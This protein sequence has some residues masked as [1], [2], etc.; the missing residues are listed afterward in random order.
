M[1][2]RIIYN[3]YFIGFM[4]FGSALCAQTVTGIVTDNNGPMPGAN[5]IVK[6]T[7]LGTATDFDGNYTIENVAS[8]AVLVFSM[9]G[10]ATQEVSVNGQSQINIKLTEDLQSLDEVVLVGYS[11]R[12]KS[13]LTGAVSVVDMGDLE[14]TRVVNVTQA[15]QGQI[16]GV[17]V[18]SSTGAPGDP[19]EVRIRGL[20]TIGDNN[21]LYV[22]D[23]IPTRD[24]GFLNQADIKSMT[25]LKDASAAAIYGSRASGGVVLITTKSGNE[26]KITFD[27]NYFTGLHYASNLPNMLNAEQYM[28][29]VEKAWNNSDRTGV[30]PY[31]ADKGRADF[32]NTDWLD[33]LFETGRS[34]NLQFTA[35]GGSDKIQFLMS[36]GYYGQDGMVIFDNDKYK[37]LSYRTNLNVDLTDRLKIG[38]NLQLTYATQDKLSSK[39]DAP[40]IIRHA[41]LRPPVIGVYKNVNDPTYSQRDP[42]TDLPFYLHN[43]RDNG[44]WESDKYEWSQNPIALAYFTDDVRKDFRTFGNIYAEYSFLK[45]KELTF[46]TNVGVDLSFIHNKAFR[47]NFGDDDGGGN[48][49]DQGLGRQNRPNNLSEERGEAR[50]ITFNNTLNYAKAFNDKHDISALIGMEYIDNY[51]S[52]I[53]ASRARFD[54]TD[55]TFRYIDYGATEADLWNGG[56]A[57][58]WALFSYFGSASY[59]LD[60]KYMVTAN[61]RA[62][63]SSR[64]SEKNRWGYFP[65]ISA[66]WKISDEAFLKD[67]KWLSNL[68]LRAGWGKLGNQEIDNYAFLTLINQTDGK[69]VVNR[70]GNEDLKW[71]SSEST[72]IGVDVGFLKN[73]LIFSAEYYVK[74]T[75]DILL[76]IG[77]PSI[78]G[79]VSPTIVNAGE[80]SNK[81]FEFSLNYRESSKAFQYSINANLGTVVNNVEKLH[82]NVPNLVGEVTRTQVGQPLNAY[83]GYKMI[84]IYQNQAEIDS[85]LS[86]TLNPSVKPGDI[87]FEDL[88]D[89][90][91]VNSDDRKFLGSSIP[92]L[93]YGMS[94]SSSYKNFDF[95]FLFQGVEGVDRYNDSK[96]ILDYDTRPFN[97]TTNILGAW[98]GEGTSNTIPRVAFEDNGSSK[99]SSIFVEDA[100]YLRLK[101]IELGYT[102][103]SVKGVQDI[104]LYVSGQNLFTATKYTGMDP[105]STDLMDR[106]TYPSS[107]SV[108]F[109]LN[110]KF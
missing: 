65:S 102:I 4:L 47:E 19:I 49:T 10:Y 42:F 97:Y 56:S 52:S 13:T 55:S 53:G 92:D 80:V 20:G 29:T 88:N 38:T 82:P 22:I 107:S 8:N 95:S 57:S 50:T 100:S 74:N 85:H 17:Q 44:G 73:K 16:A 9:V 27:V 41:L 75:S 86:G 101:N 7:S 81:G 58:E 1:K 3:L 71:E 45:D 84:G 96:K 67:V 66:G 12:K 103:N 25:V 60:S 39:G 63:A 62:D 11:S 70:Y 64:F 5:V 78:V 46:R 18:T 93:T 59:V 43:D 89:D 76:P 48:A 37:R 40:G 35:S 61:M 33:E 104:R 108:L 28:N 2:K 23:G 36:L 110:V 77:L 87:K 14:K 24:I 72:N 106:G 34:Q 105:E 54:N 26:G 94:F 30:N 98:D 69:V 90:G 99:V 68:K 32:S 83:Y 21:P 31:T 15:L 6:G 109:G 51:S 79:D 91:I